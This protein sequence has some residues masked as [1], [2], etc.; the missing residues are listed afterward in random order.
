M[1]F[2]VLNTRIDL[3]ILGE[4]P[5]WCLI[6]ARALK[7]FDDNNVL[8]VALSRKLITVNRALILNNIDIIISC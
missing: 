7:V 1:W 8:K 4:F 5:Q 3:H 6:E 2:L